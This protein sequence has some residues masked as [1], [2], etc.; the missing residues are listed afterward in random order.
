[1]TAVTSG[2]LP[3]AG[4]S[5][6]RLTRG[7]LNRTAFAADDEPVVGQVGCGR[8]RELEGVG[9]LELGREPSGLDARDERELVEQ[10]AQLG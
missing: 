2:G 5:A 6:D 8:A 9:L 7:N 10:V 1:V 3:E 4:K